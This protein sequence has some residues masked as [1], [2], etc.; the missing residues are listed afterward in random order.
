[1]Y[2]ARATEPVVTAEDI[3]VTE[4]YTDLASHGRLLLGPY[5]RFG[6]HHPGPL[7]FYLQAPLYA[8]SNRAGASLF[9]GA[10]AINVIAFAILLWTIV[11]QDRPVL[12]AAAG[13]ACLAFVLRAPRLLASPWTPHVT[14]LPMLACLALAAAVASGRTQ[15]LAVLALFVSFVVQTDLALGPP[16]ALV[17]LL[18][19]GA[20]AGSAVRNGAVPVR[21][22]VIALILS[23]AVWAPLLVDAVRHHGGNLLALLDFFIQ[24]KVRLHTAHEAL[25]AWSSTFVGVARPDLV[26]AWGGPLSVDGPAWALPAAGTLA[27]LL[28]VAAYGAVRRRRVF[29]GWFAALTLA[30]A[31]SSLWSLTSVRG[32]YTDYEVFWLAGLGAL[33]GAIVAFAA[34]ERLSTGVPS[35]ER[36]ARRALPMLLAAT[37]IAAVPGYK[38]LLD[39]ERRW[40]GQRDVPL[41][42]AAIEADLDREHSRSVLVDADAAW[43]ISVPIVLRLRQHHRRV[44]V[45]SGS[46]FIFTDALAA[47]GREDAQVRVQFGTLRAPDGEWRQIFDSYWADVYAR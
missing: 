47:T 10:V 18:T 12:A 27:A 15:L 38:S 44:A 7:Y 13:L 29:D 16:L 41:A 22:A 40:T 14:I 37:L 35:V 36:W 30:A 11:R 45:S 3:G 17:V 1:M 19:L 46:L 39:M 6:W 9:V 43:S 31:L 32:D 26:L 2:I 20:V 8:A 34:V 33:S 5:S 42:V 23:V 24:T 21:D 28:A 4:L 25:V